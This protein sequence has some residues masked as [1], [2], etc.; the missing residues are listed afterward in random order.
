VVLPHVHASITTIRSAMAQCWEL[1]NLTGV[2]GR[3][4]ST[5]A[6]R[7]APGGTEAR[8]SVCRAPA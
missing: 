6:R 7:V 3:T 1:V 5:R 4:A 2:G 8:A